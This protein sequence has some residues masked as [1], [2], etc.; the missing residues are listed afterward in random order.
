LELGQRSDRALSPENCLSCLSRALQ[1]NA[2]GNH[3]AVLRKTLSSTNFGAQKSKVLA[4][5]DKA[6]REVFWGGPPK[7]RRN[8]A[9][10]TE[11]ANELIRLTEEL[12]RRYGRDIDADNLIVRCLAMSEFLITACSVQPDLTVFRISHLDDEQNISKLFAAT[13][14]CGSGITDLQLYRHGPW[15]ETFR[16]IGTE[17]VDLDPSQ[18]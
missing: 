13:Q 3:L 1:R 11:T 18:H 10:T 4:C 12:L 17:M 9:A 2:R 16:K 14:R 6:A 7:N 5:N 8:M 15:E